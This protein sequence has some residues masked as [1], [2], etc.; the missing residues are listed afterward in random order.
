MIE[1]NCIPIVN[2]IKNGDITYLAYGLY[3]VPIM[4]V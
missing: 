2:A 4:Q 3:A 1:R